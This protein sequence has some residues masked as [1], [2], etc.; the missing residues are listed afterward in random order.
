VHIESRGAGTPI[1]LIHG[2]GVDH[3][4]LLPLDPVI[5]AAGGWRRVYLDLPGMGRSPI[6]SIASVAQMADAVAEAVRDAVGDEPFA[7]VGNSFGAVM[8]RA[9][10]QRFGAQVLGLATVAGVFQSSH[11]LRDVPPRTVLHADPSIYDGVDARTVQGYRGFSVVE[12]AAGLRNF[13][14]TVQPGVDAADPAAL[15]LLSQNYTL[16]VEPEDAASAPFD[17]PALFIAG[18]QD[19]V[20][21]YADAW[22]R[23]EHYPRASLLVLDA[24]GHNLLGEQPRLIEAAVVE[25]LERVRSAA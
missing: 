18:R 17:R 15:E 12:S 16:D 9:V 22:R 23:L 8:A 4:I 24:A 10:A 13:V 11:A 19:D 21:G 2:F 20:V 14:E 7:V 6:G 1:V 3:R 5:E 25:W